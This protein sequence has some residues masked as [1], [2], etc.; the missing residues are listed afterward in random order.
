MV[1]G[2]NRP[3][4][5]FAISIPQFAADGTF[6][7]AA[8]RSYL[9]T[10]NSVIARAFARAAAVLEEAG[11]ATLPDAVREL[12]SHRIAAW[13]GEAVGLS[14][15]WVQDEV[16][17]VDAADRPLAAF[18]LLTALAPFQV[19]ASIFESFRRRRLTDADQVGAVGWADFT[20][21]RRVGSWLTAAEVGI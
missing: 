8:F 12:V 10:S 18:A 2:S 4:V 20:A 13:R 15:A 9:A 14:R 7:P 16:G 17:S 11:R 3:S 5:R 19:D 21:T 6:E 1:N